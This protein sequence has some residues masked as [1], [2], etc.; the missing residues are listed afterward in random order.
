M[1][2]QDFMPKTDD[3]DRYD[4]GGDSFGAIF[5]DLFSG[6]AGVG[7]GVFQDFLEFMEG[8]VEMDI[9]GMNSNDDDD[10]L[11]VLLRS[12][13]V[14][15]VGD[16]M[17][18]TDLV[19]QQMSAKRESIEEEIR[20][21]QAD[22]AGTIRF[23]ER[24]Q[25]EERIDE[26]EARKKVVQ[27]YIQRAQKRLFALQ[28]RYKELIVGG[29]NDAKA[30]G[31]SRTNR[32]GSSGRSTSRSYSSSSSSSSSAGAQSTASWDERFDRSSSQ[33]S[34]G[35]STSST[36][37]DEDDWK[38]Q[39]FGSSRRGRGSSRRNRRTQTETQGGASSSSRGRASSYSDPQTTNQSSRSSS[40]RESYR[41]STSSSSSSS[42]SSTPNRT[43]SPLRPKTTTT[44]NEPPHRRSGRTRSTLDDKKRIREIKVDE[45]FEK[46]KKDL[47]L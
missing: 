18:D 20:M 35:G 42:P 30:G 39:G 38:T 13:T 4:A 23:S 45:E 9:G 24:I 14:R 19:V 16:E 46:L 25:L 11:R 37:N 17:D 36:S 7:R 8:N 34:P 31:R 40:A 10:D 12:G 3:D 29:E 41:S 43:G 2:W 6:T 47:G 33:A 15:Q 28:T 44:S 32:G 1:D 5:A 26:L 27:G 22:M 21:C